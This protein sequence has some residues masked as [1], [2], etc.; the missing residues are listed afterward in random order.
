M[1]SFSVYRQNLLANSDFFPRVTVLSCSCVT[2]FTR[3][4]YDIDETRL[5]NAKSITLAFSSV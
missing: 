4:V 1:V 3:E 5:S 2:V